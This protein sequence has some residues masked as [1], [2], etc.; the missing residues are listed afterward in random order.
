MDL[1]IQ[2]VYLPAFRCGWQLRAHLLCRE[3][4]QL[5]WLHAV[6]HIS[7]GVHPLPFNPPVLTSLIRIGGCAGLCKCRLLLNRSY[8]LCKCGIFPE[9]LDVCPCF[10]FSLLGVCLPVF[11]MCDLYSECG[12]NIPCFLYYS[13]CTFYVLYIR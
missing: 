9:Y 5:M 7:L 1:A 3:Y 6:C 4:C 13:L 12:V 11:H 8:F 2:P 10:V